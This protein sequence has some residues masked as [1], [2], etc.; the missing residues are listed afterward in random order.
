VFESPSA[1]AATKAAAP[2]RSDK[3]LN[4]ISGKCKRFDR[5]SVEEGRKKCRRGQRTKTS[6]GKVM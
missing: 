3:M 4:L 1:S 6:N 5:C 2:A